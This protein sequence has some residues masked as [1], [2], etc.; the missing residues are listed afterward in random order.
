MLANAANLRRA[1]LLLRAMAASA[2][3]SAGVYVSAQASAKASAITATD[4]ELAEIEAYL[5]GQGWIT[6]ED[7]SAS[8]ERAYA[9]TRHG[10]DESQRKLP[11][12]P[13]PYTP[14]EGTD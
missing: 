7:G 9:L 6:L 4:K 3:W 2:G 5:V 12:E 13:K 1:G 10:L 11:A 14:R 8:G